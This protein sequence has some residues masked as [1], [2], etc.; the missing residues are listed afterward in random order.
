MRTAD[1]SGPASLSLLFFSPFPLPLWPRKAQA[2]DGN[3]MGFSPF[4]FPLPSAVGDRMS[5]HGRMAREMP[6]Q[7][8]LPIPFFPFP[9]LL[10][11][12]LAVMVLVLLV[13]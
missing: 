13:T 11:L 1:R 5:F 3:G 12:S 7:P 4:F 9:P 6:T 8:F 2:V 10:F